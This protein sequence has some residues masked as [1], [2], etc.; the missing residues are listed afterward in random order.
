MK[1]IVFQEKKRYQY[2]LIRICL[3]LILIIT[4][5]HS[6]W[7]FLI[8]A[9]LQILDKI[10][11]FLGVSYFY[12]AKDAENIILINGSSYHFT[13][14]CTYLEL[15][16]ITFPFCIRFKQSIYVNLI[17]IIYLMTA[18]FLI[19]IVRITIVAYFYNSDASWEYFHEIPDILIHIVL[20]SLIVIMSLRTDFK[21][22]KTEA[23]HSLSNN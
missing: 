2:L 23:T 9:Y 3:L 4:F 19:N 7:N 14:E 17:R 18:I 16:F 13:A 22:I 5:R 8:Q 10:L 6:N 1:Q 15:F 11:I 21:L 12:F 20:I